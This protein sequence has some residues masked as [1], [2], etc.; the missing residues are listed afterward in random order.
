MYHTLYNYIRLDK[1]NTHSIQYLVH[2]YL[3]DT[4]SGRLHLPQNRFQLDLVQGANFQED[5]NDRKNM[6]LLGMMNL[7]RNNTL[8][9][10]LA[11]NAFLCNDLDAN[12][13]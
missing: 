11:G 10:I 9:N 3:G 4:K 5:S 6:V 2:R 7:L 1:E 12:L 8:L 13:L